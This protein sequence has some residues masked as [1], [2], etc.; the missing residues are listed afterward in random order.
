MAVSEHSKFG[1]PPKCA[2]TF[3]RFGAY[4]LRWCQQKNVLIET[5]NRSSTN[6]LA[7]ASYI[8]W[9]LTLHAIHERCCLLD[10]S[11]RIR[12][13]LIPT[14][15]HLAKRQ[16]VHIFLDFQVT[17]H[18]PEKWHRREFYKWRRKEW[19]AVE[20]QIQY[21]RSY[22]THAAERTSYRMHKK[23]HRSEYNVLLH[24]IPDTSW[25]WLGIDLVEQHRSH[26]WLVWQW[27]SIER[28]P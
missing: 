9:I 22:R 7:T 16:A 28:D 8:K 13:G 12:S 21:V 1:H 4:I 14:V 25:S 18:W 2:Q 10:C 6:S 26:S 5:R 20:G 3:R 19:R 24:H 17:R 27:V 15:R 23:Q 11:F